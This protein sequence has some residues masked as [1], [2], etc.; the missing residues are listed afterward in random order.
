MDKTGK[1]LLAIISTFGVFYRDILYAV[2]FFHTF[3]AIKSLKVE[4]EVRTEFSNAWGE[5]KNHSNP[6]TTTVPC[7]CS[8]F[9]YKL[10]CTCAD[11]N[12]TTIV[13]SIF[14]YKI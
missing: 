12:Y 9:S 5:Y 4:S 11:V 10:Y 2:Q 13:V 14:L 8:R 1:L 3:S 7:D 6:Y